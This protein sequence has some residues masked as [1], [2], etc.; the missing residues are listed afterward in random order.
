MMTEPTTCTHC[1]NGFFEIKHWVPPIPAENPRKMTDAEFASLKTRQQER[2]IELYGSREAV[3]V[4]TPGYY[5][6]V[7]ASCLCRMGQM[8]ASAKLCKSVADILTPEELREF[9]PS[10][11]PQ[12]FKLTEQDLG[13]AGVPI[14]SLHWTLDTLAKK[15]KTDADLMKYVTLAREW[16]AGGGIRSDVVI[17]GPNGT[18]KS[19]IAIS[20]MRAAMEQ[21][22]TGCFITVKDLLDTIRA[23]FRD[24]AAESD[25]VVR[26]R[27]EMV[28]VLV[29]DEVSGARGS[30]YAIDTLS[31]LV[32][33]RQRNRKPTILTTNLG[34]ELGPQEASAELATFVGP[35]LFDRLRAGASFW[36]M[37]GK[38]RRPT[39]RSLVH[40]EDYRKGE[41]E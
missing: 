1:S 25:I 10:G 40:I 41:H 8:R 36:A 34:A 15:A 23:A 22:M 7:M 2:L 19:G 18:C 27:F 16:V 13:R 28:G 31:Q 33:K 39:N 29:L 17:F 30:D 9:W 21:H 20:M 32:D 5:L 3:V 26:Q 14:M 12:S 4:Q 11:T 35:A 24:D 38:S 6:P 37:F